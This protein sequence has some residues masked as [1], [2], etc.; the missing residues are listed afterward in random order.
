M[1]GVSQQPRADEPVDEVP[2][3]QNKYLGQAAGDVDYS[4]GNQR[5]FME[6]FLTNFTCDQCRIPIAR[7]RI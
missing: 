4:D 2:S 3:G 1:P 5:Y 6:D 7:N